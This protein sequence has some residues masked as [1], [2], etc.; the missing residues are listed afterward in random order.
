MNIEVLV[1]KIIKY[2]KSALEKISEKFY[3]IVTEMQLHKINPSL[4]RALFLS[5]QRIVLE[6]Q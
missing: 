2:Q 3:A 5:A 6:Y 1:Y 4:E